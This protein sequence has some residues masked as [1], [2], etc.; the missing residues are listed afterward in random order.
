M[1]VVTI[2]LVSMVV[3]IGKDS[4]RRDG[5]GCGSGCDFNSGQWKLLTMVAVVVVLVVVAWMVVVVVIDVVI[6]RQQ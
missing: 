4:N 2:G 1:V 3:A 5:S 6:Q